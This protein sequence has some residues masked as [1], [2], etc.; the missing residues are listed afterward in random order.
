MKVAFLLRGGVSKRRG[1]F[2]DEVVKQEKYIN[3]R[4]CYLFT[5]KYII[6]ANPRHDIDF[7]IQS[8]NPDLKSELIDLYEPVAHIFE[9]NEKYRNEMEEILHKRG[10]GMKSLAEEV[11]AGRSE[12]CPQDISYDSEGKIVLASDPCDARFGSYRFHFSQ[13]SQ[14]LSIKLAIELLEKQKTKYD[15][16]VIYRPDVI[17][18]ENMN[19]D[20]YKISNIYVSGPLEGEG[21]KDTGD[22][23]FVMS[24]ENASLFK[25]L[26]NSASD[27]NFR[28][29][30]KLLNELSPVH[31]QNLDWLDPQYAGANEPVEH[32][33]IKKYVNLWLG[34]LLHTDGFEV[35]F[36]QELLR[37]VVTTTPHR[38]RCA[39]Y[40]GLVFPEQKFL[41]VGVTPEEI[42]EIKSYTYR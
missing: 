32:R 9:D 35:G 39:N 23:H 16:V 34:K 18:F 21:W 31:F 13:L 8:W 3:T 14:A 12:L 33:W 2:Y 40:K 30:M 26:Y 1:R 29:N 24:Q 4:V 19:F 38:G 36:K 17:L 20:F 42:K 22:L 5:K 6:D 15:L 37:K 28:V 41:D 10:W 25:G 27:D 11:R 7:F